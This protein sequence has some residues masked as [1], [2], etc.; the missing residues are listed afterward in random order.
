MAVSRFAGVAQWDSSSG[1]ER[2]IW[3][4]DANE[5]PTTAVPHNRR[6]VQEQATKRAKESPMPIQEIVSQLSEMIGPKFVAYATSVSEPYVIQDWINGKTVPSDET[7]RRLRLT[8]KVSKIVHD[9]YP[10]LDTLQ[11]WLQGKNPDLNDRSAVV[12]IR[13]AEDPSK[14]ESELIWAAQTFAAK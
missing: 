3:L 8:Y 1:F 4:V 7:E 9:R 2:T 14:F 11:A 13:L 6:T 10:D 5:V 12:M